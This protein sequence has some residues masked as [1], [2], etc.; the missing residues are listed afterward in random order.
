MKIKNQSIRALVIGASI[1][2]VL[3]STGTLTGCAGKTPTPIPQEQPGD[4]DL[5]CDQIRTEIKANQQKTLDLV[6]KT[7]KTGKNIALGVT[8]AFFIVP[9]FF[10]DFSDAERIEIQSYDLRNNYLMTLANKKR[11]PNMPPVLKLDIRQ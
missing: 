6:P 2:S 11:C 9:L 1:C 4:L 8:G 5:T 10:M 3:L 7:N